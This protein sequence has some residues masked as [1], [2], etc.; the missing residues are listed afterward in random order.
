MMFLP[1]GRLARLCVSLLLG[2]VLSCGVVHAQS[3]VVHPEDEY[4]KLIRVSEDI[5]PLGENPFGENISLYNG[6]LSFEQ[7][8]ISLAGN[9]PLLQLSRSFHPREAKESE[10]I[11]GAF[12]DWDMEVPR[13]TTMTAYQANVMGWLVNAGNKTAR[14]SLFNVPPTVAAQSGGSDWEPH[15]WWAGYQ[16]VVPGQGSQ[17]LLRRASQ[18]TLSPQ[19][20][21]MSFPIV[22]KNH[23]MVGCLPATDGSDVGEAFFAVSPDGT[24]YWFNHMVYRWAPTMERPLGSSPAGLRVG[25]VQSL[26]ATSDRLMRRQASLL[27][28][29]IEDRFGNALTYSYNGSNLTAITASDGRQLSL[30]Y[31]TGTSRV[32]TATLQP[33]SGTPRTWTYQYATSLYHAL[34]KVVLPDRSAWSYNL[35]SFLAADMDPIGGTCSTPAQLVTGTWTGTITHPSGLTGSFD[36]KAAVHGRSYVP[37]QCTGSPNS[38][39]D[40]GYA[41]FPRVY[42]QLTIARKTF[43]GAGLPARAWNYTYSA[44][45]QSWAQD[46]ASGC[47]TQVWTDVIGP[48][49]RASRYTFSNRFDISEGQLQRTDSH[50]GAVGTTVLRSVANYYS[51][52]DAG[53]WPS[54]YGDNLQSRMNL[55]VVRQEAP[56][57]QRVLTQSGDT[58]TWQAEAFNVF[59]QIT[60]TKRFNSITGQSAVEEQ[61]SYLNDLPHWVLALPLQTDNLT[62]G[63]TVDQ[64]VYDLSKLTLKERWHF[65]Q[66]LMSYAFDAQGNL[67]R[68][69]DGNSHTTTLSNY[70]RGIPQTVVYPDST[71]QSLLVDD[72]GQITRVTDQA[73]SATGYSYDPVGRLS[74]IDYPTGDERVWNSKSFTYDFVTAAERGMGANHWRRTMI[75]G[76][77][78]QVTWFDAE[79]RPVLS[80]TYSAIDSTSHTSARTDYDWKGQKTFVSYPVAGS[81]SLGSITSGSASTYDAVGRLT[82]S[83]QT[84]EWGTL[85]TTTTYLSGARMQ[86]KDPKG[87]V[88]TTSYQVFDQPS[89]DAVIKVQAPA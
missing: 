59:A 13:I 25:K 56:L 1:K 30:T 46:C 63:E 9:G 23:W 88:T 86:V 18:N 71:T 17:D 3:T 38:N 37:K 40:N 80:D 79:L 14:C 7:T 6:S 45:N 61:T 65:G 31:V 84:S 57:N 34:T 69:T 68:F 35:A 73:G 4:K 75:E 81:P 41:V 27:V 29:R 19:M 51:R 33:A 43:S 62:V 76:D 44:P 26:F 10:S 78:R 87:N 74:R 20:S 47:P 11:D 58:Y 12:S 85:T 5:Q 82:Q 49:G 21:G 42:Y 28:T 53:P 39:P 2:V 8:D 55:A 77:A 36:L 15:S 16:L 72:F 54:V 48:D 24:K 66:K 67:A 70:K 52:P 83:R 22:T 50:D 64:N 32:S 89:Y 60:K